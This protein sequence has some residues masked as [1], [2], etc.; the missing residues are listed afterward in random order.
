[1]INIAV[2]TNQKYAPYLYVMLLS[3]FDSN[4]STDITVY[5]LQQGL[6][7]VTC[8]KLKELGEKYQV[9]IRFVDM[10]MD[11]FSHF[12]QNMRFPAEAYFR[13]A[14]PYVL[15]PEV[16]RI[17][18]LDVD[19]LIQGPVA[20]LYFQ[21]MR[22]FSF[23]ACQDMGL[24]TLD[25]HRKR[26]YARRDEEEQR[27]FNSGVMLWDLDA[28]RRKYTFSDFVKA[29][30]WIGYD[31]PYADQDI[32]N[33]LIYEDVMFLNPYLYNFMTDASDE[34]DFGEKPV[35]VHFANASPWTTAF[36]KNSY[37]K[38]W[39]YAKQT[40]YYDSIIAGQNDRIAET[41]F[42]RERPGNRE[43]IAVLEFLVRL[44]GTGRIEN[45]MARTN[46]KYYLYGAGHMAEMF[47]EILDKE[48][49]H[50]MI[51]GVLDERKRGEWNGFRLLE[52]E[53][54]EDGMLIVTPS[55]GI[56]EI[57]EGLFR[58]FKDHTQV[59]TITLRAFLEEVSS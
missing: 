18:Y 21:D 37:R 36:R 50:K 10:E 48:Y 8:G 54:V 11:F 39:E 6:D 14:M 28:V 22:G 41:Y 51:R 12:P 46:K 15:P 30:E 33:Y 59:E 38:W 57:M 16:G 20:P 29:A 26:L 9:Q 3:L 31:M 17:L 4:R 42:E 53:D 23:A 5:V 56:M 27:Y 52:T 47:Y 24:L 2:A 34:G 58:K 43:M 55:G 40:E 49:A 32:L 7:N 25:G 13:L 35:I 1:M 19:L 45:Y 44:K